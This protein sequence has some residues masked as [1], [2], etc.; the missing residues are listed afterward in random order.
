MSGDHLLTN[1]TPSRN[2]D[3]PA[4]VKLHPLDSSNCANNTARPFTKDLPESLESQLNLDFGFEKHRDQI[5]YEY[6][7][8][9]IYHWCR[10]REIDH[11]L[12]SRQEIAR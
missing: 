7:S 2:I 10:P 8:T 6:D 1:R 4:Y 12:L 9:G 3:S 11:C 5:K